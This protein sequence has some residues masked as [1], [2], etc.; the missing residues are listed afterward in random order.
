MK[1]II[2]QIPDT[3]ECEACIMGNDCTAWKE[4]CPLA[5]AR[6]AVEVHLGTPLTRSFEGKEIT[7]YDGNVVTIYAVKADKERK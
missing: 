4:S 5:N 7:R 6:E 1:T 3:E 2:L